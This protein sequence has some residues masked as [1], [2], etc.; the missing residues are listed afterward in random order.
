MAPGVG[1]LTV[2]LDQIAAWL[3]E[4]PSAAE[5]RAEVARL[6]AMLARPKS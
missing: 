5:L 2:T 1:L 6:R 3:D 4:H